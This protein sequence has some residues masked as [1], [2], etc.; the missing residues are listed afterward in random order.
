M[1]NERTPR[2][3]LQLIFKE[4]EDMTKTSRLETPEEVEERIRRR[5]EDK[6]REESK[7]NNTTTLNCD[8][9]G[10]YICQAYKYDLEG[11]KFYHKKCLNK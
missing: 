1:N 5:K 4:G 3:V 11:S 6:E 8:I 7:K 2:T 9:C 10:E